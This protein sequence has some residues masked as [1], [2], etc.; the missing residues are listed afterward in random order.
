MC[1]RGVYWMECC[2]PR[3]SEHVCIR[4]EK[5]A[6]VSLTSAGH[7]GT[8]AP[9]Y[10]HIHSDRKT[11]LVYLQHNDGYLLRGVVSTIYSETTA[12]SANEGRIICLRTSMYLRRINA[13]GTVSR[14]LYD[15]ND[16]LI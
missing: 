8:D 10:D 12:I 16:D 2:S 15:A 9:I 14:I 1:W 4:A 3:L 11:R 5:A 7:A 6:H 13:L